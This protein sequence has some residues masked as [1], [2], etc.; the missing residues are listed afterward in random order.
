MLRI[1]VK[2]GPARSKEWTCC[3]GLHVRTATITIGSWHLVSFYFLFILFINFA[4]VLKSGCV[5]I[6]TTCFVNHLIYI[7]Y[8][9]TGNSYDA[10]KVHIFFFFLLHATIY[11]YK[12]TMYIA[13]VLY[14]MEIMFV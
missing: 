2:M 11:K 9:M 8:L 12:V 10:G 14:F 6:I 1:R 5:C 4:K 7:L 3:F 13:F